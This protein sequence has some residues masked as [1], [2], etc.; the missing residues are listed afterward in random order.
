MTAMGSV[1]SGSSSDGFD[2]QALPPPGSEPPAPPFAGGAIPPPP[3]VSGSAE[4]LPWQPPPASADPAF[5]GPVKKKRSTWFWV[6]LGVGGLAIAGVLVLGMGIGYNLL[7]GSAAADNVP[8]D[9]EIYSCFGKDGSKRQVSCEDTHY[10]EV[11]SAAEYLPDEPYPDRV[12]RSFG[13]DVCEQDFELHTGF[14]YYDFSSTYDYTV[15]Y[16]S[17]AGWAAGDR[18]VLCVLHQEE[19]HPLPTFR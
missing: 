15:V 1:G 9:A 17:E 4:G 7:L 5:G 11:Y 12:D 10:F 8:P 14:D 3:P 18:V 13:L 19:L 16:P 2:P 6:A